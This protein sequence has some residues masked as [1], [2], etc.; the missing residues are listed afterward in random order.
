VSQYFVDARTNQ[1]FR[2]R[3]TTVGSFAFVNLVFLALSTN[4]NVVWLVDILLF[5]APIILWPLTLRVF[6]IRFLR[7]FLVNRE[8]R[9]FIPKAL[10]QKFLPDRYFL[11]TT[12]FPRTLWWRSLQL[13]FLAFFMSSLSVPR[14]PILSPT[15]GP[16]EILE[17]ALLGLVYIAVLGPILAI[18]WTYE[19][20]GLRGYDSVRE[21][22]YP[23]GSTVLRYFAGFGAVGSLAKFLISLNV[24]PIQG[25]AAIIFWLFLLLPPSLWGVVG[26]HVLREK[27][28]IRELK[29]SDVGR[30]IFMK[31]ITIE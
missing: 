4:L 25:I 12:S 31:S 24:D 30:A 26:F 7:T 10:Q 27:K 5:G 6:P 15:T 23:I 14:L 22:V 11:A 28:L 21:V 2:E 13:L 9:R 1:Y 18:I 3:M 19:D 17:F 8:H 29:E 20:W 16:N